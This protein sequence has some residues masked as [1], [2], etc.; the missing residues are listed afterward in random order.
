MKYRLRHFEDR[1]QIISS[2][3]IV[4][5]VLGIINLFIGPI[6]LALFFL[7][8]GVVLVWLQ[9]R[10]RRITVD[11]QNKTVKAGGKITSVSNPV[12]VYLNESR[13]S[14]NVNSRVSSAKV[15]MYFYKGYIQ[16]GENRILISCNRND[17]RD[18]EA[19]KSIAK[20]LGVPFE[21]TY[22]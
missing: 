9:N 22:E 14:Q 16:D 6:P 21:K 11:T 1:L 17:E 18:L 8:A 19:M 12:S 4:F 7:V 13:V 2:L 3:G 5:V 15:K 20:D 10:G